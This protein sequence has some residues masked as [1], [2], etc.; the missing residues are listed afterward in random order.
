ME[1]PFLL[2]SFVYQ[3]SLYRE[4][5][6]GVRYFFQP[7]TIRP[8]KNGTVPAA[9]Y[10]KTRENISTTGMGIDEST[11]A[12]TVPLFSALRDTPA[13]SG[14]ASG[15]PRDY[16]QRPQSSRAPEAVPFLLC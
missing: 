2:Q 10:K 14:T 7:S 1:V 13:K 4:I 15:A 3:P 9:Q 8:R 11:A 5:R 6:A 12:G 16:P